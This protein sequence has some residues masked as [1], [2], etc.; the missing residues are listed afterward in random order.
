MDLGHS[1]TPREKKAPRKAATGTIVITAGL[2]LARLVCPL[3]SSG[4][5][6]SVAIIHIAPPIDIA[7]K[8]MAKTFCVSLASP[9][10]APTVLAEIP[11][12]AVS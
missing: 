2:T 12:A 1:A 4:V 5:R 8:A 3:L 11:A 9:R 6:T 7:K 10:A